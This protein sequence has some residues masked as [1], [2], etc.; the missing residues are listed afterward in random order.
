MTS[1]V[2]IGQV[3]RLSA[4]LENL[5]ESSISQG[6]QLLQNISVLHNN[7]QSKQQQQQQQ[8]Q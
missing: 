7:I 4:Q 3:A 1:P 5:G 8:H 2:L 6:S